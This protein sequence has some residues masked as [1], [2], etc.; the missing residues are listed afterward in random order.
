[1][2]FVD[3]CLAQGYNSTNFR[4]FLCFLT[5]FTIAEGKK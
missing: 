4:E 3:R 1:M 2:I 5:Y